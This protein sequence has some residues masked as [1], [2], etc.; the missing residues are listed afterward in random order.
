MKT[1]KDLVNGVSQSGAGN[2][3]K[4]Q[5]EAVLRKAFSIIGDDLAEGE[6]TRIPDFGTFSLASREARQ[7]RNPATG[8]TIQIAASK[9][10]KFKPAT[11]L[12]NQVK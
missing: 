5:I 12:K 11:S 9:S 7:G 1:L 2:A 3:S 10:V 8:E 6:E 4:D